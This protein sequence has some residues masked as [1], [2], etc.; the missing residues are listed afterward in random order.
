MHKRKSVVP[1][2]SHGAKAM[3][4]IAN[5]QQDMLTPRLHSAFNARILSISI[6]KTLKHLGEDSRTIEQV[7][8]WLNSEYER[9]AASK[10][11]T[12]PGK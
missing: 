10:P 3:S 4:T 7:C 2:P 12:T 11:S 1:F 9:I 8:D 5:T 6:C